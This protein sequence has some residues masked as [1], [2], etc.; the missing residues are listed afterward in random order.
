MIAINRRLRRAFVPSA[1]EQKTD[2]L[3][4]LAAVF[5]L[6]ILLASPSFLFRGH[7]LVVL[8]L[9]VGRGLRE[10]GAKTP[11][12]AYDCFPFFSKDHCNSTAKK[13]NSTSTS[14]SF[15]SLL[16]FP[17]KPFFRTY[18]DAVGPE[19]AAKYQTLV[20]LAGSAS[21]EFFADIGLCPF[22]AVK[23][24]VQT[25]PG[26]ARGL[27]DGMPKFIATEGMGGLYKG[28]TPLWGRQIPYTMM[29][30]AAFEN[31]VMVRRREGEEEEKKM[32]KKTPETKRK[33]KTQKTF[34]EN[35]TQK[36]RLSTSTWSPS[37]S[38]SA[39]SRSSSPS[40]S[41]PDTSPESS[42][43]SSRTR[44]TTW[45]PSSTPTRA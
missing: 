40:R 1:L 20:F 25:V 9:D 7:I 42:A 32:R 38:P 45:S 29:K 24:K 23:V 16:S 13:K 19:N 41:P 35:S 18:A 31:T 4:P 37:P 22:E 17:P 15:C 12:T 26:F 3:E 43:P 21:A 27:S 33:K 36:N 11:E 28:L 10:N 44:P 8:E 5:L 39:P 6:L 2:A 14:F 30:F 34:F